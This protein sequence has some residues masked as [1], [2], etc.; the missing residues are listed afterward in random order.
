MHETIN[1]EILA[2]IPLFQGLSDAQR[3]KL[4][5]RAELAEV[6]AGQL[7][8]E[9]GRASQNLWVV[10]SGQCE[11]VRLVPGDDGSAAPAVLAVLQAYDSFGEMSFFSAATHSASVRAQCDARLFRL[12]RKRYDELAAEEPMIGC[13]LAANTIDSLAER[14]RRMDDWV[15]ELMARPTNHQPVLEF[16]E[17]RRKLFESWKL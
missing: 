11:V 15:V 5:A 17:L 10:L 14:L 2:Q 4:V 8:L 6:P 13:R 12:S 3:D 7:I 1:G 16:S 9:Q